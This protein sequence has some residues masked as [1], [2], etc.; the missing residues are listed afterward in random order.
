MTHNS[1]RK[2][3]NGRLSATGNMGNDNAGMSYNVSLARGSG[4]GSI[5]ERSAVRQAQLVIDSTLR[6]ESEVSYGLYGRSGLYTPYIGLGLQKGGDRSY[7]M[8]MRFSNDLA[9]TFGTELERR[10]PKRTA[11][12]H[13][14]MLTGATSW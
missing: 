6:F 5:W 7:R 10:E 3:W 12:D 4:V 8:G 1:G 14:V 2:G 13:R 11:P 9:V